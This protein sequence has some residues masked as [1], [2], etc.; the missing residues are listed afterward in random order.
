MGFAALIQ[1]FLNWLFGILLDSGFDLS[2]FFG[3]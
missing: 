1:A 3:R 2:V